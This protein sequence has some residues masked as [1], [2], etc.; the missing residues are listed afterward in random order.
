MIKPNTELLIKN[1]INSDKDLGFL[2]SELVD[3]VG[4]EKALPIYEEF[5]AR[6]KEKYEVL[7]NTN[8][9]EYRRLKQVNFKNY[10]IAY[11]GVELK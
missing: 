5:S 11:Y 8:Y 4:S 7:M 1:L 6:F 10:I 3:E 2:I 9:F